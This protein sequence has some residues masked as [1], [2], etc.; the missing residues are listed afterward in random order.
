MRSFLRATCPEELAALEGGGFEGV[1]FGAE[2]CPAR[3]PSVEEVAAARALCRERGLSFALVSPLVRE[4]WF[5]RVADWLLCAREPGEEVIVNDL[6]LLAW[7]GARRDGPVTA[8]RLLS[9]QRRDPRVAGMLDG[10]P[11]E[12]AKALR[13]SLWD[14]PEVFCHFASYGV[15]RVEL[16]ALPWGASPPA[17][18]D[19]V[20]LSVCGPWAPV[21]LSPSCP[22]TPDPLRCARPCADA[23]P[24]RLE[25]SQNP[26]PLWSR[27]LATFLRITKE[28]LKREALRLG[29]D[30][31]VV[32]PG[33][34]G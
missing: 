30:R 9:R 3:L 7:L 17:L 24:V 8:G 25:N 27:G 12:E 22:W 2:F 14:D 34:P 1:A 26:A 23:E 19:G 4:A 29:A 32:S 18:P 31:V 10:A 33:I 21:T 16:D 6:G 20:W 13:G 11:P 28:E 15:S 5:D